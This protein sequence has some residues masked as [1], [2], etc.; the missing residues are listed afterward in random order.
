MSNICMT[1]LISNIF[2]YIQ[3][4]FNEI[5]NYIYMCL[6]SSVSDKRFLFTKLSGSY[7]ILVVEAYLPTKNL[8]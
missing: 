3:G 7:K 6:T 5:N 2:W 8:S 1:Q 4:D